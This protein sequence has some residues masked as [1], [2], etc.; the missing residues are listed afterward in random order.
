MTKIVEF[1][2]EHPRLVTAA[3][4]VLTF[5]FVAQL[6]KIRTDT[7]PKNMLPVTSPVRQYND[8]V[9]EWFALHPDVIVRG[10]QSDSGIFTAETLRRIE[11]LTLAILKIP[12]V[13]APDVVG[14][15]T[16]D[17][18]TSAGET[19]SAQ[20]LLWQIPTTAQQMSAFERHLLSNPL[21][22]RA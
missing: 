15:S 19:L 17:D 5:L 13:V 2:V 3:T 1:S 9:E 7:D 16:V 22:V 8:Q 4:L 18:V 20:P 21:F 11:G 14:L 12:G 10:I 6:P